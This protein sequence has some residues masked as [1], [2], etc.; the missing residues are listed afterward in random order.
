MAIY[1]A[2]YG[3]DFR[4][5]ETE[6]NLLVS[7]IQNHFDIGFNTV[8]ELKEWAKE[9]LLDKVIFS[10]MSHQF[11]CVSHKGEIMLPHAYEAYYG[12]LLFVEET[13]GKKTVKSKWHPEGFEYFSKA[14]IVGEQSDGVHKPLYYRDYTRPTGYYSAER[15]AFN[16]AKPFPV[17]AQ[18]TG[19]DTSHIY[20]YIEHVAGECAYHLLA[21][22]RAKLLYPTVKTQIVPIIV[23][24]AQGSGKTTFAE[25][26]CK[27]LFGKDNVLVSDQYDSGA[28]FNADYADALI[29]CLEEKEEVDRRNSAGALKSRATATTIRKEQKGVDPIYQESYTDFIMTTNK[30]VP[31]KFD[32]RED[33]RRFMIMEAD[34]TFTRKT[35]PTADEVFTKLYGFDANFNKKGTPFVED[36]DLIAQFKHELFTR[37]DIA[38]VN[39]RQFPKTAAYHR[40]FTLPRTSEATEIESILRAMAPFIKASLDADK[41]VTT[42]DGHDITDVITTVGA[43]QFMPAFREHAKFVALCRPLVFYKMGTLEPFPHSTVERGIYDCADWL[44]SEYNLAIIPDMDAL[45]GGF[46]NVQ[47]RYRTAAS[48]KFCLAEDAARAPVG[49]I[50]QYNA[51][52]APTRGSREGARFRVNSKFQPDKNGC[53]ETV[54]E[55][56]VGV[57]SLKNKTRDV[58]YLDTFLLESDEATFA[59]RQLEEARALEWKNENGEGATIP[60]DFLYKERLATSLAVGKSLFGEG[61]VCRIVYSGAK[62]YHFLIRVEDSP[63]T[64]EE[65]SWLHGWLCANADS[66]LAFDVSTSDPAR[67]TRSPLTLTR[68]T[69]AHGLLVEGEQKLICEDW[70]HVW[71]LDWRTIYEGWKSR[72]LKPYEKKH[73]K[74]MLPMA[75]EY[76]EAIEALL[77]PPQFWTDSKFDGNR[78]HL[79][80]PAYR[81][82][83]GL[84]YSHE[85]LWEGGILMKGVEQ[86]KHAGEIGY[87]KSRGNSALIKQ[88]DNDIDEFEEAVKNSME[89]V[90]QM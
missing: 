78:Q 8:Q 53:F 23:S 57:M 27:G 39:L 68:T 26:I 85:D 38:E 79:F 16:V 77:A 6:M 43:I 12:N 81:L 37:E 76:R 84:G 50:K 64:L 87:W 67:L 80:F 34:D 44:K 32:G 22:L 66:R 71:K 19:R 74:P 25:V 30:D 21:W 65:Y 24:R 59:Q 15:D 13:V 18:E 90:C 89:G 11:M 69:T 62:S 75:K 60:A 54:N 72:P 36:R 52:I 82:L 5:A 3:N 86:Y 7:D 45:P 70:K 55:M 17:F 47:G 73:G 58:A 63:K 29:V 41:L 1:D 40:C 31:I 9:H 48:A 2:V 51:M 4:N 49:I 56:K 88:I 61:K 42:V 33:Q 20:T 83:R 46:T 10:N 14:Y 35:S 28:R